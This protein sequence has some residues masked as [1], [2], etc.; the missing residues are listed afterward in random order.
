MEVFE[1]NVVIFNFFIKGLSPGIQN[2][3]ATSDSAATFNDVE[4]KNGNVCILSNQ[5][6]SFTHPPPPLLKLCFAQ[7]N[8]ISVPS[9]EMCSAFLL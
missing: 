8:V 9:C 1:L 6:A 2:V 5:H 7:A 3:N 4:N